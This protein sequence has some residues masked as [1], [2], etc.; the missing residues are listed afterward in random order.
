M[1]LFPSD[2][3]MCNVGYDGSK[4]GGDKIGK[5]KKVIIVDEDVRNDGKKCVVK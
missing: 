1:T 5:P 4:S 2:F 3:G